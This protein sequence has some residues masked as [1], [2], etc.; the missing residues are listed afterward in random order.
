MTGAILWWIAGG[1]LL[2]A[3]GIAELRRMNDPGEPILP[4]NFT[5]WKH[6]RAGAPLLAV[7][8]VLFLLGGA[9]KLLSG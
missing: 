4:R 8:A 5:K 3:A 9:L 7:A 6:A 2:A 1:F